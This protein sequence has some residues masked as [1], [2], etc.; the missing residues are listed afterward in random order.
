[1]ANRHYSTG[2]IER[3]LLYLGVEWDVLAAAKRLVHGNDFAEAS[4]PPLSQHY[5]GSSA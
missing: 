2:T 1:M 4:S 3:P 5:G